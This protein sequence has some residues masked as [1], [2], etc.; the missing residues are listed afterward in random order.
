METAE[1]RRRW[2]RF[3]ADRDHTVV[4]SA[5]PAARR[6]E[7]AVRQRR[8]G[9]VQAVLPRPGDAAV[10]ARHQRAEV[11]AHP[12]HRGGRQDHP[13]RHVLPD[14]RQ[15]LLR[16]LLQGRRHRARLGAGH[17]LAGRRRLR[18]RPESQLWVTVYQ[19]D[20]EAFG[21]WQRRSPA[22]PRTASQRLRQEGQLLVTWACPGPGGPCSR[23]LLSTAAPSTARRA[24]RRSTSDRYLE[25]WNLVF[26]QYEL[27]D[28]AQQGGLRHPRRAAGEEHRHRHGPRAGR[29]P[30]AG[31][32]QP[33]RDRR[34]PPGPR[35]GAPSCPASAYGRDHEDDVR[36]RVVADHVRSALMLIGDG[37]TPGNEGR[38][39]V[40]RRHA[41]A[42]PS[43]RCGCSASTTR[44]C[45]SCCRSA[46]D[47]M[48]PSVPRAR[49]PT[50]ARISTVAYAEEEAFRQTLR[51][52]THDLR[53]SRRPTTK[54]R[55]RHRADR[56]RRVPA[57]RHLRLPDRPDPRDGGRAGPRRS[58][59][60][61][62]AGS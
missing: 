16:R 44:R 22:C 40:L 48:A 9:A 61:A 8:H 12:R 4:P 56:R 36:L 62:S 14:E 15:L 60:T 21:I 43:A 7:P 59:R 58:T 27:G 32:R 30:P 35:P 20:D 55:G 49:R 37:V 1:I 34:G 50:S 25:F 45:P 51:A 47:A 53:H 29:R 57:A 3:F 26:M 6:P 13:A 23:D 17:P 2:L 38:G 31:R 11:R 41:C 28:G 18:L 46:R 39:Y 42:A 10:A 5:S 24:A 19:D 54:A 52:G 33:L